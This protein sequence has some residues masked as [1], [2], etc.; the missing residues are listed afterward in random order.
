VIYNQPLTNSHFSNR[1]VMCGPPP[2]SS[3]AVTQLIVSVM[4]KFYHENSS[5]TLF[6]DDALFY[7]RFIEAQKFSYAQR[8]L[9]GDSAFVASARKLSLNM[10]RKEYTDWIFNRITDH[11]QSIQ[12]YG[13]VEQ[14]MPP[15]HGTTHVSAIDSEGN[16]VSST[17]T[18]NRW[19]GAV[20]QSNQL[21]IVWNDEMDDF[22]TPGMANGFGFAPSQTNFIEPGKRPMSSMSPMVVYNRLTGN[23]RMVIGC[24]GG[25]KII[26]ALAK[27]LIRVLFFNETI[28]EAIDSPSL[29]NQFTPDV[30]QYETILPQDLLNELEKH[31]G[32]RFKETSGLEGIVQ[33]IVVD[34]QDGIIYANGDYRRKTDMRPH[35]Q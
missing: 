21:G 6:T 34:D 3:F 5:S 24:S 7:H 33:G 8:T 17:S 2:P 22:S 10:T 31:Y 20:V 18:V 26:S 11:A 35:G 28:K 14:F 1:L 32:Q 30:T 29:H 13:G 12:N 16:G 9:L 19:F 27:P 4:A 15:D 23:L 25:S